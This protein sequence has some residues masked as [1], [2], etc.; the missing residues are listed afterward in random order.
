MERTSAEIKPPCVSAR[1]A[2]RIRQADEVMAWAL[3]PARIAALILSFPVLTVIFAVSLYVRTSPYDPP[4]ALRHLVALAGCDAAFSV[5]LGPT[6]REGSPGY[7]PRN[8]T[9]GD[10][11]ACEGMF[12][13]VQPLQTITG[14]PGKQQS[15]DIEGARFLRP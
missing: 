11:V 2:R 14:A 4:R 15:R 10:G 8:D 3:S 5:G 6:M 1:R 12:A 7:H 9:D 13:P